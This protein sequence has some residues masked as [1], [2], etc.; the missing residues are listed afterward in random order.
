MTSIITL[1]APWIIATDDYADYACEEH[2]REWAE[3]EGIPADGNS[4]RLEREGHGA[5]AEA[6]PVWPYAEADY[7]ISCC[8]PQCD[9]WLETQLTSDG[10]DYMEE[11]D[12]PHAVREA[13]LP[14]A[15]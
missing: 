14:H 7:P 4:Y 2:A 1:S 6:Y 10:V 11:H 3:A 9:Q 15:V 5:I 8:D 13:Y 12:I